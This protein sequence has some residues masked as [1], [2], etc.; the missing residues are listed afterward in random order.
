MPKD[1]V[2]R[3]RRGRK[4][5]NDPPRYLRRQRPQ[6]KSPEAYDAAEWQCARCEWAWLVVPGRQNP[7]R[8]HLKEAHG[9][10]DEVFERLAGALAY[11]LNMADCTQRGSTFFDPENPEKRP[12]CHYLIRRG[13][14]PEDC[15]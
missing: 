12:V 9:F 2:E 15:Y 3:A 7:L 5:S 6:R 1:H 11:H 14:R 13:K 8:A 10:T 4:R